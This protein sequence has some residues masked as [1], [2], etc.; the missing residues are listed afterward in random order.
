MATIIISILCL[1]K[2]CLNHSQK[3]ISSKGFRN[4]ISLVLGFRTK[5][6]TNMNSDDIID[7]IYHRCFIEMTQAPSPAIKFAFECSNHC[8]KLLSH[9]VPWKESWKHAKTFLRKCLD[10]VHGQTD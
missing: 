8:L 4:V 2:C 5:H 6:S 10:E 3:E 7:S 1:Q 9:H